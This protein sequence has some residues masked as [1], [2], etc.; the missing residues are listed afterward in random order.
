M[1]DD[2]LLYLSIYPPIECLID[3]SI[4]VPLL[5]LLLLLLLF[6]CYYYYYYYYYSCG[7]SL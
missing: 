3:F 2:E 1:D 5:L 6:D 4:Y 7:G